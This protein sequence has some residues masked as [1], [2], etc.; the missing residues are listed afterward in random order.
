MK[1][2]IFLF[3]KNMILSKMDKVKNMLYLC[4]CNG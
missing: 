3:Y 4:L 2:T 1:N